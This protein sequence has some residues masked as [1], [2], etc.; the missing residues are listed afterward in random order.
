MIT[1]SKATNV[2]CTGLE[3]PGLLLPVVDISVNLACSA[4][5]EVPKDRRRIDAGSTIVQGD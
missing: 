5:L 2:S 1:K 3:W 4:V